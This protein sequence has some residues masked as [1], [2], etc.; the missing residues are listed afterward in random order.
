MDK[1]SSLTGCLIC[2]KA[3][4]YSKIAYEAV[5]LGCGKRFMTNAE[6]EDGHFIC[7]ECHASG[8]LPVIFF[9]C[10]E[11]KGRDPYLI[12]RELMLHPAV[13][14]HG[15]ENHVLIGSAL[16]AACRNCGWEFDLPEALAT[17]RERGSQLPGGICGFWGCCGAAVSAGIFLS[18]VTGG[19]PLNAASRKMS[20]LLTSECLKETSAYSGARCC[21]RDGFLA[22]RTAVT[23]VAE[24]YGF[25]MELPEKII[26]SFSQRNTECIKNDCPFF[27]NGDVRNFSKP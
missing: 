22:L 8:S 6:C 7:D 19:T 16:L 23:F 17:M 5:C 26:C 25:R 21:K 20:N 2:G 1:T 4:V 13:H 18:I 24:H 12:A 9:R 3:L 15:P 14:M 10:G 11:A 27:A